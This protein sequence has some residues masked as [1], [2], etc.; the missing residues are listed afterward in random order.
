MEETVIIYPENSIIDKIV[1][2]C[3]SLLKN[4]K[5]VSCS[6]NPSVEELKS[7]I[8]NKNGIFVGDYYSKIYGEICDL[9]NTT[10]FILKENCILPDETLI[11]TVEKWEFY[12]NDLKSNISELLTSIYNYT[13]L[14]PSEVDRSIYY[15]LEK[16]GFIQFPL[17]EIEK[18]I[19][20]SEYTR[21][22][23][24]NLGRQDYLYYEDLIKYRCLECKVT[25]IKIPDPVKI[26]VCFGDYPVV[27]TLCYV[28]DELNVSCSVMIH[29]NLNTSVVSGIA[30]SKKGLALSVIKF[31][32]NNSFRGN[33]YKAYGDGSI[34]KLKSILKV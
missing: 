31:F 1:V 13:F 26:S 29:I 22:Y 17:D 9:C 20:N 15:G 6:H 25:T 4:K 7:V 34:H 11:C 5:K 18:F 30:M 24:I 32:F 14:F 21:T 8:K 23:V 2:S 33:K 10:T 16:L 19:S 27:S 12:W 3:N 28:I